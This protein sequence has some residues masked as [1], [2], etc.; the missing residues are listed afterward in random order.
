MKRTIT[1]S[2]TGRVVV[3]PDL[4]EV[5]LGVSVTRPTVAAARA[6]AAENAARI[7]DAVTAAGVARADVRTAS[8]QV[9]PEYDYVERGQRLRGQTV[10]HQY[11]VTVRSLDALGRVIDDALAAGAT[12]LDGVSFRSVDPSVAEAA[13]RVAAVADARTRAEALATEAGVA[14]GEV[15]AIVEGGGAVPRP[16]GGRVRAMAMAEA[17]PTPV[18]AGTDE[19][20][21]AITATFAIA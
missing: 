9:Q 21:I 19:V 7:L 14:V 12:T 8:L 6:A 10:S 11:L 4:A 16:I 18:E 1:V 13:A 2:G 20:V 5:R 17:A 15:V 3:A